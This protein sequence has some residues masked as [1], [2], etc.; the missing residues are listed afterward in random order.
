MHATTVFNKVWAEV[1]NKAPCTNGG[2]VSV[3]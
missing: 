3:R 2:A 1:I